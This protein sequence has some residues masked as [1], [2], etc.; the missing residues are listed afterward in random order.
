[1]RWPFFACFSFLFFWKS[2]R[3]TLGKCH[4]VAAELEMIYALI[5]SVVVAGKLQLSRTK[6]GLDYASVSA[7]LML[8][9]SALDLEMEMEFPRP[10]ILSLEVA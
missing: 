6:L 8:L 10:W 4:G 1:M 7:L 5:V 3:G 2:C 9:V